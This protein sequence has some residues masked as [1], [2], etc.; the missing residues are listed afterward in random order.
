MHQLL[1]AGIDQT[2][3]Q[4]GVPLAVLAVWILSVIDL[5]VG[6]GRRCPIVIVI[7]AVAAVA[8]LGAVMVMRVTRLAIGI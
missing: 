4:I 3:A 6:L 2:T 5:R 7:A 1:A 8:A